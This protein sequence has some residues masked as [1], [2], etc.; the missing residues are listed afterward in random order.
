MAFPK[1]DKASLGQSFVYADGQLPSWA[2]LG[3]YDNG[4]ATGKGSAEIIWLPVE[5]G[6]AIPVGIYKNGKVY[7]VHTD[8]LGTPR[9][10]TDADNKVVWQLAYSAPG[11]NEP[12]GI[13]TAGNG[14]QLRATNPSIEVNIRGAGQ[15][16]DRESRLL[17]NGFRSIGR[18]GRYAQADPLGI[19]PGFNRYLHVGANPFGAT[20]PL[21]LWSTAAHNAFIDRAFA[22]L[23]APLREAI[24][25]GSAE[26]DSLY[27]QS[28]EY[29]FMH[30]MSSNQFSS[31]QARTKYCV[32]VNER[33]ALFRQLL[34]TA[35]S[36]LARKAAYAQLGMAMHAVMD[37]TSPAHRGFQKWEW[38]Q[39]H[40]HGPKAFQSRSEEDLDSVDAYMQETV[41]KMLDV[42]SGSAPCECP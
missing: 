4:T 40:R 34:E 6:S 12:T 16:Y 19:Y 29:S 25:T 28:G 41:Q 7:A 31:D 26:A 42:F 21:G 39:R 14:G 33:M 17:D 35:R 8:H 37:S 9:Q 3:E 18:H 30:A 2:L 24:K 27:Y 5:G 10:I 1:G 36:P 20:D 32:F 13:L 11:T 22:A 15:Y 23:P 38:A